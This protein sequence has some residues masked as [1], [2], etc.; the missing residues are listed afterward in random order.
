MENNIV[1][2]Y[3]DKFILNGFGGVENYAIFL[4]KKLSLKFNV[5][6]ICIK[7]SEYFFYDHNGVELNSNMKFDYVLNLS[8]IDPYKTQN[9][10]SNFNNQYIIT[11]LHMDP[12]DKIYRISSRLGLRSITYIRLLFFI[13]KKS[14]KVRSRSKL[15]KKNYMNS[16]L[17]LV[18]AKEYIN[19][20]CSLNGINTHE[21]GKM[22]FLL[23]PLINSKVSI[24]NRSE[25]HEKIRI[26]WAGRNNRQK[27]PDLAFKFC[28]LIEKEASYDFTVFCDEDG[29]FSGFHKYK[30]K[31]SD[32]RMPYNDSSVLNE[33][34][35]L[36]LT[37]DFEGYPL[38]IIEA[39]SMGLWVIC[40]DSFG[41]AKGLLESIELGYVYP[42]NYS[43][44]QVLE[45]IKENNSAIKNMSSK[46]R[47]IEYSKSKFDPNQ[48]INNLISYIECL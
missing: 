7:N 47:R 8:G 34:D 14:S 23:N 42:Y 22:N 28:S 29:Y 46:S 43:M 6:F 33:F 20:F 16:T 32:I 19:K 24:V 48:H 36:L 44:N 41:A 9:F 11:I 31:N 18:I 17:T 1:A 38:I 27:R 45:I 40:C 2:I 10:I 21:M 3:Y 25:E 12:G 37:S 13:F 39:L 5:F 4:H 26:V 15:F 30:F 35:V